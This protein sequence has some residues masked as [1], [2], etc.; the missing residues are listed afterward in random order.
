MQQ[1]EYHSE[2]RKENILDLVFCNILNNFT[3]GDGNLRKTSKKA[4]NDLPIEVTIFPPGLE[5]VCEI[6]IFAKTKKS[7]TRK[8]IL[9]LL[10]PCLRSKD[11]KEAHV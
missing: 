11:E 9:S 7:V 10:V 6:I 5:F 4:E 2:K 3:Y 1:N 8:P